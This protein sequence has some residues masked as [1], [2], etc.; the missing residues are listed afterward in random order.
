M[1]SNLSTDEL[2]SQV[3]VL[4]QDAPSD[5]QTR[6]LVEIVANTLALFAT[7]HLNASHY[8]LIQDAS[9]AWLKSTLAH[10]TQSTVEKTAIF[11]FFTLEDASKEIA[12]LQN[13][14]LSPQ[15]I[16]VIDLLFRFW[17][18]NLS[19]SLIL[20]VNPRATALEVT[21]SQ[22]NIALKE[23]RSLVRREGKARSPLSGQGFGKK[24]DPRLKDIC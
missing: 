1:H 13:P 2:A 6:Q 22:L 17:T 21:R 9:G 23:A 7:N 18:L 8:Y 11:I 15:K 3:Q 19:D 24:S 12:R 5:D 10:R 16:P 4:I 20:D 14:Q